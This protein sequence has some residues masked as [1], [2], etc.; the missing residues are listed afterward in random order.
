MTLRMAFVAML[1]A[2][3]IAPV[4]ARAEWPERPI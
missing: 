1:T 4:P 3:G 2:I